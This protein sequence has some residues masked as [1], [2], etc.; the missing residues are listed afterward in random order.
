MPSFLTWHKPTEVKNLRFFNKSL[1]CLQIVSK[2]SKCKHWYPVLKPNL[3]LQHRPTFKTRKCFA[4]RRI[5]DVC[6]PP[7]FIMAIGSCYR[8]KLSKTILPVQLSLLVEPATD[9]NPV[10]QLLHWNWSASSW[11]WPTGHGVQDVPAKYSPAVQSMI[12]NMKHLGSYFYIST[13]YQRICRS[14]E[15]LP[16]WHLILQTTLQNSKHTVV[17]NTK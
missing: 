4:K 12:V 14:P 17:A 11:Y 5:N 1:L 9:V 2:S 15:D 10:G 3:T 16:T 6:W 13:K 7:L 8:V